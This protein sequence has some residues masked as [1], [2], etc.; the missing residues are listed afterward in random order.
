MEF[1]FANRELQ[2]L[3][4]H[5]EGAARFPAGIVTLFRRRVRHI[6]AAQDLRDLQDPRGV[7]CERLEGTDRFLLGLTEKYGLTLSEEKTKPVNRI[8]IHE[9]AET[10]ERLR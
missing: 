5:D 4:T 6:E 10:R 2:R 7:R 1:V 3:Y 9:I 8:V